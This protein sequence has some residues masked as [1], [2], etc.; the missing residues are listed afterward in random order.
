MTGA[1]FILRRSSF[2]KC[3]I[4]Y[5]VPQPFQLDLPKQLRFSFHNLGVTEMQCRMLY[6]YLNRSAELQQ[7]SLASNGR[8]VELIIKCSALATGN[9]LASENSAL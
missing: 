8:M 7:A 6:S 2:Y 3:S 4:N 5:N 1:I 9:I